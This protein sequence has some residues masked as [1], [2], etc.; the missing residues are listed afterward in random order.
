[1]DVI[2]LVV[3]PKYKLEYAKSKKRDMD[4][5]LDLALSSLYEDGEAAFRIALGNPRQ[6][7]FSMHKKQFYKYTVLYVLSTGRVVDE[8]PH[9]VHSSCS[10]QALFYKSVLGGLNLQPIARGP[11]TLKARRPKR[12]RRTDEFRKKMRTLVNLEPLFCLNKLLAWHW[13]DLNML[14][15]GR[16]G[17]PSLDSFPQSS[18]SKTGLASRF[19]HVLS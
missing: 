5:R 4:Q 2:S 14:R 9:F 17:N 3:M 11:K 7:S 1:M 15:R 6:W 13:H 18:L 10:E 16:C 8:H 12:D 19:A